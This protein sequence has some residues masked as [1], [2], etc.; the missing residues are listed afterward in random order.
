MRCMFLL[1][2]TSLALAGCGADEGRDGGSV[3]AGGNG[4]LDGTGGLG[5]GANGSGGGA[6]PPIEGSIEFEG[7]PQAT[8]SGSPTS[9]KFTLVDLQGEPITDVDWTTDDTRIGSI[10]Q[11]G[12]FTAN[13]YVGGVV[14]IIARSGGGQLTIDY[15][16]D[17]DITQNP[18]SVSQSDQDALKAG[19]TADPELRWLYPYDGTVFPRGV[20]SPEMQLDGTNATA[21]YVKITAPHYSYQMFGGAGVRTRAT[22]PAEVWKGLALTVLPADK[23]TVQFSKSSAGGVSG[24]VEESWIFAP[25]SLKGIIYYSSYDV[26]SDM[27]GSND[28]SYFNGALLRVRPADPEP[29]IV[30]KGCTVCHTVS[31]QGN[32]LAAALTYTAD[33]GGVYNPRESATYNVAADGNVTERREVIEGRTFA[34]AAL[35]PDGSKALTNGSKDGLVPPEN[36]RGILGNFASKLVD[37]ATGTQIASPSLSSLVTVAQTPA[38]SPDGKHVA[39]V[40]G[41]LLPEKVLSVM[42]FDGTS[43]FSGLKNLV[44]TSG[45]GPSAL[46]TPVVAWPTFLPDGKSIVYHVGDAYDSST[47]EGYNTTP[48]KARYAE[49]NMVDTET[50][51]IKKLSALNG[52]NADGASVLPYGEAVENDMNYEPS[53]LPVAVGGYYWVMFTSRRAYGNTIAP[54]GS[55]TEGQNEPFGNEITPSKRKKIWVAAID[56]DTGKEDPSHPAFYLAG[57]DLEYANM[58]AYT[59]MEPCKA[60]GS[61]CETGSDCCGGFCRETSRNPDGTPVLECVPKPEGCSNADELC[62]SAADCCG[63]KGLLCI[64][65]RCAYPSIIK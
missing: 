51:T 61:A 25:Q 27:P 38:F 10:S 7:E 47:Y 20:S 32:V 2:A 22:L 6:L 1:V 34:L 19:G 26:P 35:T 12:T 52:R 53:A 16:V 11:D 21:T 36:M 31:A 42:D 24:P 45:M 48:S 46:G 44:T 41:D 54:G 60:D 64:N 4:G 23:A 3:G 55:M 14:Q 63:G 59:A 43:T 8:V 15:T 5:L 30:Q 39:F 50:G 9:I 13:G 49:L 17:V 28:P 56:V 33:E 58:R 40:N 37:T 62:E 29:E 65:S 57:Q 18:G